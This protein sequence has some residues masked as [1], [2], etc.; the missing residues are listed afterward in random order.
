M[1]SLILGIIGAVAGLAA[2]AQAQPTT[3]AG[4]PNIILFYTDDQG[5]TE[6][7]VPMMKDRQKIAGA[8]YRTPH[9]DR[10]ARRGMR[11]SNAYAP[12]PV[13]TPSRLSIQYGKTPARLRFTTIH[14]VMALKHKVDHAG[15]VSLAQIVKAAHPDYRTA[16][17]GKGISQTRMAKLGY[18][19]TDENDPRSPNG[20][21]HGDWVSVENRTPLPA[22]DPKR[23][24]SLT[25][26][27][28][29]Y[30][31]NQ[32]QAQRPFFMMVSHYAIHV[33]HQ[34]LAETRQK[35]LSALAK[36]HGIADG[37]PDNPYMALHDKQRAK[38]GIGDD[39]LLQGKL[40]TLWREANYAAMI[41]NLD[42]SL[43]AILD[44]L[45]KLA[46]TDNTYVIF[47]SDNGGGGSMKPLAG[48][49]A[50]MWEGGIRVPLVVA[51]PGIDRNSQCDVPV[52]QW[53]LLPTLHG[54]ARS[55]APLPKD[56]DGRSW[57]PLLTDPRD[58]KLQPRDT[59]LVWHFPWYAGQPISAIRVGDY[60]LMRQLNTREVKLFDVVSDIGETQDLSK[61]MPDKAAELEKRL[62]DYLTRVGAW[63]MVDVYETRQA[64]LK[65]WIA[66]A[67]ENIAKWERELRTKDIT[68]QQR[69]ELLKRIASARNKDIPRLQNTLKQVTSMVGTPDW[70]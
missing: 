23:I 15:E 5:W 64:E 43:G 25:D 48:G 19:E 18:D 29:A 2:I 26:R 54:L 37:I 7:S 39:H 40:A 61:S 59:G 65:G 28:T 41:E 16:F 21:L 58:G 17:F 57:L 4:P 27:A 42:S 20:N 34:S 67:E 46:I 60:K 69:E 31:R 49:K 12:S 33:G 22:K 70:K 51:G 56:L 63:K 52:A 9:L 30:M 45:D 55:Q 6:T 47:T 13:C 11:F 36:Q 53:D 66:R 35:Y 32:A 50:K 24:F 62:D 38:L 68:E 10:L 44:E 3:A 14:D 8:L 1:R